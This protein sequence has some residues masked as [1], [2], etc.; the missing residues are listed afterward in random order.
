MVGFVSINREVF[1]SRH[2]YVLLDQFFVDNKYQNKGIGKKLFFQSVEKAKEWG[3]DKFYI[4]A[5][6]SEDTLAFYRALGCIDATEINRQFFEDD[7]NDIQL[8]YNLH[9]LAIHELT[10]DNETKLYEY[11]GTFMNGIPYYFPTSFED[12]RRSM[13][14]DCD[15]GLPLFRE[16]QTFIAETNGKITG[17]IQF[18]LTYF[19]FDEQ[20]TKDYSKSHAVIRNLHYDDC[21]GSAELLMDKA[22]EYF[23]KRN[24]S[25]HYAFFHCF[26]MS[27]YARQGKLHES[28]FHAERLLEKY[29][30]GKEHENVY[31]VKHLDDIVDSSFEDITFSYSK[32]GNTVRFSNEKGDVGGCEL[33]FVPNSTICFLRWIW[34][35]KKFQHQGVGTKCMN[36]LFSELRKKGITR[37]DTDTIDTNFNAQNYYLKMGFT[38]MGIM[39]SYELNNLKKPLN[40]EIQR[41]VLYKS[42]PKK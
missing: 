5:G 20:G 2:K 3:V 14:E 7:E 21:K 8:E 9:A 23:D 12:W 4:C 34:I 13:F 22:A 15:D 6:S 26:G 38:R 32:N 24:L 33:Y 27:C 40:Y 28:A 39:R 37:L 36:K 18:G 31:F 41:G 25:E 10:N 29:G 30:Y 11:F 42:S 1:G 35:D 17:F 19:A 16:L